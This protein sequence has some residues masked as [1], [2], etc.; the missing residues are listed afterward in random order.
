MGGT[1]HRNSRIPREF[2]ESAPHGASVISHP[3]AGRPGVR[4]STPLR[5]GGSAHDSSHTVVPPPLNPNPY[6]SLGDRFDGRH[7]PGAERGLS[8]A[9]HRWLA[10]GHARLRE[11]P[12][13]I[14]MR[15]RADGRSARCLLRRHL[16][17]VSEQPHHP[18]PR[19]AGSFGSAD[20]LPE[21]GGYRHR[22]Q[23]LRRDERRALSR[24]AHRVRD[25]RRGRR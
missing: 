12:R 23:R 24:H 10:A 14:R 13:S 6:R 15:S 11:L 7:R 20:L 22:G 21:R 25:R 9:E 17:S 18:V 1:T 16:R 5:Q 8:R 3:T 4:H 2:R 19:S